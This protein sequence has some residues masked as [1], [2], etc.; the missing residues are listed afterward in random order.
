MDSDR[1]P[2][3]NCGGCNTAIGDD[4]NTGN[5]KKSRQGSHVMHPKMFPS[6]LLLDAERT[7]LH[8]QIYNYF[9]WLH[10]ELAALETCRTGRNLV[11][12]SSSSSGIVSVGS[13]PVLMAR[14]RSAFRIDDE[15]EQEEEGG[16]DNEEEEA[17]DSSLG[18]N[19]MAN[20]QQQ[21]QQQ[22][23]RQKKIQTDTPILEI[24][25]RNVLRQKVKD[26]QQTQIM[27]Q[28]NHNN[29]S[30]HNHS[31][32]LSFDDLFQRL[33]VY[34]SEHGHTCVSKGYKQDHQLGHWVPGLRRK[35]AVLKAKGKEFDVAVSSSTTT[36]A[37][38]ATN[39]STTNTTITTVMTTPSRE[40]DRYFLTQDR[41]AR[42]NDM[43]FVWSF[44]REK[45]N[46]WEESFEKLKVYREKNGN[47]NVPRKHEL[48]GAFLLFALF[49]FALFRCV[50]V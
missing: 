44:S 9:S 31:T 49:A 50:H 21:Q 14:M 43:G 24:M 11:S 29:N 18:K 34:K 6:A 35:M 27:N 40:S 19:E 1:Y 48:G 13:I 30:N 45:T 28:S 4:D 17:A 26:K 47:C 12:K 32:A 7:E 33:Q 10:A 8:L 42:L 3:F 5:S 46:T 23:Q 15:E 36:N 22:Q 38:A 37:T 25:L 2:N 16:G 20:K 41:I 39:N